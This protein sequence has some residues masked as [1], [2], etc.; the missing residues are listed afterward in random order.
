M[1]ACQS[2]EPLVS[3]PIELKPGSSGTPGLR[4]KE[5]NC[6]HIFHG[7]KG[8]VLPPKAGGRVGS[9]S[10]VVRFEF[11]VYSIMPKRHLEG[12]KRAPAFSSAG[13]QP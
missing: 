3:D 13:E 12:R 4:R 2:R 8:A 5:G 1:P 11:Y 9:F 6:A 7:P 10:V